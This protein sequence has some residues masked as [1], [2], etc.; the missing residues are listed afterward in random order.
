MALAPLLAC[1]PSKVMPSTIK[2]Q[3]AK[4]MALFAPLF[5]ILAIYR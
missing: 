3:V 4:Y 1:I 2:K 5:L